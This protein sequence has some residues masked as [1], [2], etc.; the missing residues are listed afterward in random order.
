MGGVQLGDCSDDVGN[1]RSLTHP[2]QVTGFLCGELSR[3]HTA[4]GGGLT[5]PGETVYRGRKSPALSADASRRHVDR[6]VRFLDAF[7]P[8]DARPNASMSSTIILARR[9]E[10]LGPLVIGL[11]SYSLSLTHP[12]RE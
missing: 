2:S 8:R 4:A 12:A 9:R 6:Q 3:P 11:V 10:L 5:G 7:Q 1:L